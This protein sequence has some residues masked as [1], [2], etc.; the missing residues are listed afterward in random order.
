MVDRSTTASET[1]SS[2][3]WGR[4]CGRGLRRLA[5]PLLFG[6]VPASGVTQTVPL[7]ANLERFDYPFALHWFESRS[8]GAPDPARAW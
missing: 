8:A 2:P 5:L 7:G 1:V 6:L 4:L 3:L